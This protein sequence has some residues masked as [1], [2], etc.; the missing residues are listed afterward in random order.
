MEKI[1]KFVFIGIIGL[2]CFSGLFLYSFGLIPGLEPNALISENSDST[3]GA[4]GR[5]EALSEVHNITLK[6]EYAEK[7]ETWENISLYNYKTSVLDALKEKTDVQTRE[8]GNGIL[9]IGIDG[10]GGDWIYYVNGEYAG[11]GAAEYYLEN[12]DEI[13]WKHVNV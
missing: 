4:V 7:T 8:Y 5:S 1:T 11:I 12:E 6:V 10:E 13:H 3:D 9:V 2:S